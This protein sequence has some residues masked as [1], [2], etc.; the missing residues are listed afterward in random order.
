MRL[1]EPPA[2]EFHKLLPLV[3]APPLPQPADVLFEK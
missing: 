2:Q 1:W 3:W